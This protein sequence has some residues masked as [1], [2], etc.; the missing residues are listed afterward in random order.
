MQ[1]N[2]QSFL[3]GLR[4]HLSIKNNEYPSDGANESC[5]DATCLGAP[6]FNA[7]ALQLTDQSC[8]QTVQHLHQKLCIGKG[9]GKGAIPHMGVGRVLISLSMAV[10]LVGG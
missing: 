10:E 3:S 5:S 2:L 6:T 1:C 7:I 9:K 8:Q 4:S